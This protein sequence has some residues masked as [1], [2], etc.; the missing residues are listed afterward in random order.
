VKTDRSSELY[1]RARRLLPGGVNSPAR[2]W[3]GVGG[4]PLFFARGAGSRVWDADGNELIDYV[5]SWGPLILGHAHPSVVTAVEEA[6]RRGT[7]YGAP[8]EVEVRMAE[9]VCSAMPSLEMVR[10][11]NSGTEATMSALRLARAFTGR[12]RIVKFEGAYH[13]HEDALLVK[14]GSGA[15]AHGVPTSAGI[16][17]AYA[18]DTLVAPYNDLP[19][20][21]A[22]FQANPGEIAAVIVEP[23]AGNM[24]VVLPAVGYLEGLRELT[25]R[26]RALL[27]FDEVITGF[28]VGWGGA[29]G[30][31]GVEPDITTLGKIVG[32]GLP[33]G[34]YGASAEIMAKVAPLGP[35]YQ[36]GTLSGNPLAMA[37]GLATLTELKAPGAYG[38]LEATAARLAGGL[39]DAFS[40]HEV[41]ATINRCG[42]LLTVFFTDRRVDGWDSAAQS[43]AKK[44]ARFFHAMV[45]EGIY[46]PPSQYEAWFVSLAHSETDIAKTVEAAG[47]ALSRIA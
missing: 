1:A 4:S 24:G 46:L 26:H 5:C 27:I 29:Q 17:P 2:S 38:V 19:A 13:G 9:L 28:R 39:S 36:A 22:L 43:D 34:A 45:E 3:G 8:T 6:A 47:R 31:Y 14:A 32:G 23:V 16:H 33:V 10:F 37:A 40:G 18:A 11:V 30:L 12:N 41:P 21:E 44:Y 15:A 7:S 42:S 25:S 20:V 35:M